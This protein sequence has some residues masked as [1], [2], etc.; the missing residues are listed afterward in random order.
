MSSFLGDGSID[1][2][3]GAMRKGSAKRN[4][5]DLASSLEKPAPYPL[6]CELGSWSSRGSLTRGLVA[7][8]IEANLEGLVKVLVG[9]ARYSS[10]LSRLVTFSL[11]KSA[12]TGPAPA[13][14]LALST[15]SDRLI[16]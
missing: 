13:P 6:S 15:L 7:C 2:F 8:R 3:R 9:L 14:G 10:V 1:V 11:S 5:D 4:D 16:R 12:R